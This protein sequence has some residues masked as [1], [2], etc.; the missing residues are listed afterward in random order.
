VGVDWYDA[1]AFANWSGGMLPTED[2]WEKA[3]RGTDGRI[4]PWGNEWDAAR[5][6]YVERA[7]EA[8]ARDLAELEQLL[9]TN[10]P[11][12]VPRTPVLPADSLPEGASPYGLVQMAGNVWEMTR[13]NFFT[14][15][16]MDPF[17]KG[18]TPVEYLNRKEAFYVIRGG[19]WTSPPVCL[20]TYYR[21]SDLLTDKH[22]EIGFR[23]SYPAADR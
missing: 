23:C 15:K 11:T 12:D 5:A 2:Q 13:T 1:W 17:C 18:R 6:N 19:T 21:G 9:T 22:N 8:E 20:S 14:R 16:D 10:S 7:F 3:A 4:F